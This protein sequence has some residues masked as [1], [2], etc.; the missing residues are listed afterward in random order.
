MGLETDFLGFAIASFLALV[1]SLHLWQSKRGKGSP[2]N[3]PLP[4]GPPPL[5]ILGNILDV[6]KNEPWKSFTDFGKKYGT[7][8]IILHRSYK[9]NLPSR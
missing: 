2:V 5:P 7:C 9:V 8:Q 4:P 1:V 3:N 6:D